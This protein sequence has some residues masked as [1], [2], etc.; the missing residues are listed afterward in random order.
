[1]YHYN[2]NDVIRYESDWFDNNCDTIKQWFNPDTFDWSW[3]ELLAQY[4]FDYFEIWWDPEKYEWDGY[5][6]Y[7]VE[8]CPEHIKTWFDKD[9]FNWNDGTLLFR[10]CVHDIDIWHDG[11]RE[12]KLNEKMKK[13]LD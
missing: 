7:L 11:F 1:M 9:K 10:H 2:E 4:C 8:F 3:S 12:Y 13:Y 6:D 5:S